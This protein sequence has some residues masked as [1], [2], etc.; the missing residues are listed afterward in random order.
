MMLKNLP[1]KKRRIIFGFGLI[2][3][4][5]ALLGIVYLILGLITGW[6]K[7]NKI[8][9]EFYTPDYNYNIFDDEEYLAKN[10]FMTYTSETGESYTITD[11][12]YI[13][14]GVGP[15]FFDNFF[16]ILQ[17]GEH[18]AYN[19]LFTAEYYKSNKKIGNFTMQRVYNKQVAFISESIQN[20]GEAD[21]YSILTYR[22]NYCIMKNDGTFRT[23]IGS[24]M[25]RTQYF[26]LYYDK[27]N[28]EMKINS[29]ISEY[30]K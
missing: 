19:D 24:D 28:T 13:K 20:E 14:H 3:I 18:E 12:N 29:I 26:V 22:V 4:L 30:H 23:D 21:E 1:V 6:G 9:Y 15:V 17:Y 27:N 10:L 11:E 8:D 25:S 2:I 5:L 7:N 16:K